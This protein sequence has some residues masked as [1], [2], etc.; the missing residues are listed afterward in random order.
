[1]SLLRT[2][3]I[4]Q[5]KRCQT[6]KSRKRISSALIIKCTHHSDMQEFLELNSPGDLIPCMG[7]PAVS[8]KTLPHSSHLSR[9]RLP[10]CTVLYFLNGS[11]SND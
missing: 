2:K 6:V 4:L 7:V 3:R 10:L 11:V 5:E 9:Q 8:E 1:M